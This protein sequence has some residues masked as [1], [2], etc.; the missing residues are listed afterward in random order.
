MN[1]EPRA[2]IAVDRG[3]ATIAVSLIGHAAGR[4]RLIGATAGPA[5]VPAERLVERLRAR[6]VAADPDLA[7]AVGLQARRFGGRPAPGRVRHLAAAG[8]GRGRRHAARR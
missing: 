6:L 3:T 2:F 8:D 5:G 7:A 1:S 4:W